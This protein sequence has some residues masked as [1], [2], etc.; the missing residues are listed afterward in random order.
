MD[1]KDLYQVILLPS[2]DFGEHY[3]SLASAIIWIL[4]SLS[5]TEQFLCLPPC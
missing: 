3:F 4:T 2:N 5:T 1:C